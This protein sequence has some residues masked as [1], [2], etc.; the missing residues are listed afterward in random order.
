MYSRL[1]VIFNQP[2]FLETTA[3]ARELAES[4]LQSGPVHV[5]SDEEVETYKN[6]GH[7]GQA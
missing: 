4:D 7:H 6:G 3:I 1:Y 5:Y 2:G